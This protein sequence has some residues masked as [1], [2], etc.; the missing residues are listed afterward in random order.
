MYWGTWIKTNKKKEAEFQLINI[1][2]AIIVLFCIDNMD[3]VH[4]KGSM[5]LLGQYRVAGS[6]L[7]KSLAFESPFL[8]K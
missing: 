2:K 7:P 1:D 4:T 6:A 8:N 5:N 3:Y